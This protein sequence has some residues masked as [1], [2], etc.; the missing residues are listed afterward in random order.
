MNG[1]TIWAVTI[2]L[3]VLMAMAGSAQ[4]QTLSVAPS[5]GD[6]PALQ[7]ALDA[8]SPGDE[9]TV[10]AGTYPGGV[11]VNVPVT[12]SGVDG[13]SIGTGT[14]TVALYVN[15]DDVVIQNL[16][17]TAS[18]AGIIANQTEGFQAD[19]CRI[20]SDDSGIILT[21]CRESALTNTEVTAQRTGIE[22]SSCTGTTI[23]NSRIT[24]ESLGLSIR[25]SSDTTVTGT[26][27]LGTEVGILAENAATC[28]LTDT[29]F[30][31]VGGAILGIGIADSTIS[32]SAFSDIIQYIQ[33]YAASG[34]RVEAPSLQGPPFFAADIFSDTEYRFRL[35]NVTGQDVALLYEP[36]E[37][38]EG[39]LLFGDAMNITFITA[40]ES[41]EPPF[42]T[43]TTNHMPDANGIAENTY[44]I[45]RID[46]DELFQVAFPEIADGG[47]Q[48]L[49]ATV[50]EP[51]H[52]ALM[53][54]AEEEETPYYYIYLWG[55]V[56]LGVLLLL[57]LWRKR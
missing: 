50:T 32:G 30:A 16:A 51:G 11:S 12:L 54:R 13:V 28:I 44:G 45:Y 52:F 55:I 9:I 10:A 15:A 27:I 37:A 26:H 8:A 20:I 31:G 5:G 14:D 4:A 23:T 6:Y 1:K 48:I 24:A 40:A 43:I 22:I 19:G 39:Y 35:Y 47:T 42:A 7:Q 38:P 25:D 36:Y 46:G 3:L 56:A 21:G 29:T 2:L 41:P 18:G 57:V 33:F 53:A 17:C 49:Q 34:C